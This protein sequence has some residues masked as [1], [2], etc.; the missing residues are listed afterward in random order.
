MT[1]T[2]A[3]LPKL[4]LLA[5]PNCGGPLPPI[6][7]ASPY[8]TC[9]FCG[10]TSSVAGALIERCDGDGMPEPAEDRERDAREAMIDPERRVEL[11]RSFLLALAE[12]S[13][14]I[15]YPALRD[16]VRRHL[17]VFGDSDVL[18]RVAYKL[19]SDF[20]REA[21][22][23]VRTADALGRF[24]QGYVD[25]IN[26]LRKAPSTELQLPFLTTGPAGPVH[27]ARTISPQLIATFAAHDPAEPPP[28]RGFFAKLF[29]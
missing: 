5:C 29:G 8:V 14:P 16:T 25:A 11:W 3:A 4:S 15:S 18:A 9:L 28:K 19:A 23:E 2:D 17:G 1:E 6:A 10:S 13:E 24:A 22:I 7:A 20:A 26:A 12:Q 21:R 27:Y